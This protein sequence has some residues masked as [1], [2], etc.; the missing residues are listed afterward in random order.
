[1]MYSVAE[2][3]VSFSLVLEVSAQ[4]LENKMKK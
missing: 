4:A 3:V 1:M 2:I